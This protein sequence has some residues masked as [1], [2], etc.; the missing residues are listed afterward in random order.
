M[1]VMTRMAQGIRVGIIGAGW[2][3]VK[4]AEGYRGAGGMQVVAVADL[5]PARRSA[6]AKQF[7]AAIEYP[8]AEALIADKTI[9]VVS[10]CLP[11]HLHAPITI[12]ALK[13]GK[14]VICETAPSLDAA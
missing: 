3:G 7:G 12:K 4:H 14:H 9:A 8:D 2:P 10:L 1:E 11:N 5:I 6:L 13:S